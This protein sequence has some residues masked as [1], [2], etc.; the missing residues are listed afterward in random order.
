[1][2]HL[3]LKREF[4]HSLAIKA[5]ND[6]LGTEGV[7][8]SALVFREFPSLRS[9]LRPKVHRA[10][11]AE[12][13]QAF[14]TARKVMAEAQAQSKLKRALKHQSP[15]MKDHIYSPSYKVLVWREK[16]VNNRIGEFIGPFAFLHYD[17]RSRI[18]AVHQG[19]AIKRYSSS[20]I[21][22]FVKQQTVLD[23]AITDR[24]IED[25]HNKTE[26]EINSP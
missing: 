26:P 13:V 16:I 9:L 6:T 1:M 3:K 19:G 15:K 2:D 17:E 4:L 5:C 24:D 22:P 12:Q 10:T 18:V 21:I 7:V 20:Q 14:L 11:L 23:D 25:R 8:P